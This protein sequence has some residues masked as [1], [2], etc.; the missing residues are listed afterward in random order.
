MPCY[1]GHGLQIPTEGLGQELPLARHQQQRS[2]CRQTQAGRPGSTS[3]P[4][5]GCRHQLTTGLRFA[6]AAASSPA[7]S[8]TFQ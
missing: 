6:P 7:V 8:L 4:P 2:K 3:R 5:A 1:L